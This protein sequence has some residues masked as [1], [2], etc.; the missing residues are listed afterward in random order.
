MYKQVQKQTKFEFQIRRS[1]KTATS[2]SSFNL[3]QT[4]FNSNKQPSANVVIQ[5]IQENS[6]L[7]L[8]KLQLLT[9]SKAGT[10]GRSVEHGAKQVQLVELSLHVPAQTN[11]NILRPVHN[12]ARRALSG[13][14]IAITFNCFTLNQR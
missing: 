4:F 2:K 7:L 9:H 11:S 1:C 8:L 10:L 13:F 14:G 3:S 12:M 5:S 6:L